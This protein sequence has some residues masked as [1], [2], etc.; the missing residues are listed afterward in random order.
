MVSGSEQRRR[1]QPVGGGAKQALGHQRD[2]QQLLLGIGGRGQLQ[3]DG[4]AGAVAADRHRD[5]AEPEIVDPSRIADDASVNPEVAFGVRDVR[6]QRRRQAQRG[7]RNDVDGV[8][9]WRCRLCETVEPGNTGQYSRALRPS[10][11]RTAGAI[12]GSS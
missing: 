5:R 2:C 6:D 1:S 12:T 9:A 10:A 8:D 11:L 4:H 3:P 7:R